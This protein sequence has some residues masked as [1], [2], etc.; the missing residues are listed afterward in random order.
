MAADGNDQIGV[1]KRRWVEFVESGCAFEDVEGVEL[2]AAL[3]K[4][5]GVVPGQGLGG[6][7][8]NYQS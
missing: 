7:V 6:G 1:F 8:A 2:E 4:D 3:L 5:R